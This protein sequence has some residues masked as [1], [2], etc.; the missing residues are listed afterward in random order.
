VS[1]YPDQF[2]GAYPSTDEERNI[3]LKGFKPT[4]QDREEEW[5]KKNTTPYFQAKVLAR[6]GQHLDFIPSTLVTIIY[7]YTTIPVTWLDVE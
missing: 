6:L 1:K 4:K 5:A 2:S 7:N 3:A